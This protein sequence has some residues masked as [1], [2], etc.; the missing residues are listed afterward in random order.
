[1]VTTSLTFLSTT[2]LWAQFVLHCTNIS[3]G[4]IV[5]A[6]FAANSIFTQTFLN[7]N[8][9]PVGIG[10]SLKLNFGL[11]LAPPTANGNYGDRWQGLTI[12]VYMPD[13]TSQ[14]LGP[15]MSD[16]TGQTNTF[17][18]PTM[19]GNYGFQAIFSGQTLVGSNL[20]PGTYPANYTHIGDYYMPSS[21]VIVQVQVQQQQAPTPSPAPSTPAPTKTPAQHRHPN[22][23]TLTLS[24]QSTTSYTDFK[25]KITGSLTSGGVGLANGP[26]LLSYSI[27]N[28]NSWI[29]LT[30]ADTN[31]NGA[32]TGT[33]NTQ[34][35]GNYLVKATYPGNEVYSDLSLTV[36]FVVTPFE[37]QNVFSVTSNSTI[38]ALYFN[39]TS[40]QL[41][42]STSGTS[43]TTGY[44]DAYI[45]KSLIS[46]A[47]KL[48]V[49]LDG[50]P[51]A[52]SVVDQGDA[53]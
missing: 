29:D 45:P 1:M 19:V 21:S 12:K 41:S 5:Q 18:T 50:Q 26:I 39:S 36:N 46:D 20:A 6:T 25:V 35:S 28:G 17:Y 16:G 24:C 30:T 49:N 53:W 10:E 34:A 14:T 23:A 7:V 15:F 44:V 47:S 11:N 33:W 27:N 40:N 22:R 37:Q 2:H 13:G 52:Y 42:F 9:N 43:G 4:T 3:G 31:D 51:L 38:T 8:P 48:Q 32:F